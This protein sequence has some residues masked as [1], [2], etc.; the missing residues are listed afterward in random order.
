MAVY[1]RSYRA[2]SG[3]YTPRWSRF[4][5]LTRYAMRGI[6]KSRFITGLYVVSFFYPLVL[7]ALMYLNHNTRVLSLLKFDR[8]HLFTIG[9]T[10]FMSLMAVQSAVAFLMTAFVG[11]NMIAPDLANGGLPIYFCRPLSRAEYIFGKACAILILLSWITWIPGLVIFGVET[12]LSGAAWGWEHL[13]YAG[14]ILL[15]SALW[16]SVLTLIA[17]ALSAWVRWKLVAGALILAVMFLTSGFAAAL[18]AVLRTKAGFYLDPAVLV[19][20]IYA[21]LFDVHLNSGIS[22]PAASFALILICSFCVF[23]LQ[24]K[25]RAFE[26]IK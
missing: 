16:I 15:G 12:S 8:D 23:L 9:G 18:N 17:L 5:I 3:S 4:L 10:F 21:N 1:K 13:N 7:I 11:P 2:Y 22:V 24:K 20:T 25:V 26:V 6:F 19:T 14:G